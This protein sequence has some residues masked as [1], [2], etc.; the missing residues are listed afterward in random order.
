[1]PKDIIEASKYP[2]FR[3][4]TGDTVIALHAIADAIRKAGE[5]SSGELYTRLAG[6]FELREYDRIINTLK[7]AGLVS[8][9]PAHRLRWVHGIHR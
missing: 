2:E 9:T 4:Q 5:I 3:Q 6:E 7:D 1:M 8:E